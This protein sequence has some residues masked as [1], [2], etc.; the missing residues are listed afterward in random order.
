MSPEPVVGGVLA[1]VLVVYVLTGI[2]DFGGGVWD[3]LASGPR[4]ERQRAA[5]SRAI[6]PIWEANHV[7][8]ILAI[9]LTFVCFPHA[10][11]AIATALHIPLVL[12]LIGVVLRGSAFVF[13]AYDAHEA[14]IERRWSLIFAAA[15]VVAPVMLGVT[16]GAVASGRVRVERGIVDGGY[17]GS[18]FAPFPF[19]VGGL[20]LAIAAFLAAVYLTLE[21]TEDR[22]LQEDFR[23][24]GLWASGAVF[25]LAWAA[26]GL[27]RTGAPDIWAGLW[28]SAWALPFQGVVAVV[29]LGAI[30]ALY[31]RRFRWARDLAAAEAALVVGGWAAAQWPYTVPPLLTVHDAA[32][33]NVIWATLGVLA[34]GA[35]GLLL[36]YG[37]MMRVFGKE[38]AP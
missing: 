18:W 29:G 23:R 28:R 6:G 17:V 19:A 7:W 33:P 24:R 37:W 3:L 15:S 36:A 4:A 10:F 30:A 9:V 8:L 20:T 22:D 32:P 21:T 1:V 38:L 26:F 31:L 35:P 34:A 2:A 16:V 14:P 13:R 25:V 11:A 5:V 12:L 27:A